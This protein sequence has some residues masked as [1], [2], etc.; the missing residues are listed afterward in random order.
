MSKGSRSLREELGV[1]DDQTED[2]SE[3]LWKFQENSRYFMGYFWWHYKK[4]GDS[5]FK[6]WWAFYGPTIK[7]EWVWRFFYSAG[8]AIGIM[9]ARLYIIPEEMR[10]FYSIDFGQK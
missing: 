7:K 9:L 5:F 1:A 2:A 6:T 10:D 4:R 3:G 8:F